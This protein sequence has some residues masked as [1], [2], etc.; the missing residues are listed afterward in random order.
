MIST[1]SNFLGSLANAFPSKKHKIQA[2]YDV[3]KAQISKVPGM[4]L[5]SLDFDALFSLEDP[6]N[7]VQGA[8]SSQLAPSKRRQANL[9]GHTPQGK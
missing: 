3:F 6:Q 2:S 7:E 5:R 1:N 8:V 4:E 9:D